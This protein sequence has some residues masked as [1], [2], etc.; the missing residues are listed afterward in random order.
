MS[1]TGLWFLA[2]VLGLAWLRR[3]AGAEEPRS[4]YFEAI[5]QEIRR[6][7]TDPQNLPF[8]L[9]CLL[10]TAR[11]LLPRLGPEAVDRIMPPERVNEIVDRLERGDDSLRMVEDGLLGLCQLGGQHHLLPNLR[12]VRFASRQGN[13][14]VG[15]LFVPERPSGRALIFGH[16]GFGFK[17]SWLDVMEE[18]TRHTGCHTLALDFEGCGESGGRSSWR[19]RIDDFPAAMDFLEKSY[20]VHDFALGGHSGGGAYPAACA[21]LEDSRA[22]VL[23][24]WDCI[25]DFYDTHLAESAPDPGGNPAALLE[26]TL[27]S[28]RGKRV[29]P[30]EVV[31]SRGVEEHLDQIYEEVDNTLRHFRHPSTLLAKA[32]KTRRL[33]ILHVTAEDVLQQVGPEPKGQ[34]FRLAAAQAST[35]RARFL[36]RE[37]A[38]H[39][40]GL[41]NRPA[42][43][44]DGWRRDLGQPTRFTVISG[45]TH[46]FEAP[47]RRQATQET[48][49]WIQKYLGAEGRAGGRP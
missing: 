13:P 25:F 48:V 22:T 20:Q 44:W 38:F 7:P 39:A 40:S 46:A 21:A 36:G 30:M 1:R 41:F 32:Q 19:A 9:H 45:T 16:G 37:L 17:E 35:V 5:T 15:C 34:T 8:R 26:Q 31:A 10:S 47:G 43:M 23:V 14:V 29:V 18:I 27:S 42:G 12:R 3:V 49:A 33:A 28:S 2:M 4:G 24:L 6:T 11:L